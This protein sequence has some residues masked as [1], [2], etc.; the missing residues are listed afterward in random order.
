MTIGE[1]RIKLES[2]YNKHY[3]NVKT[4]YYVSTEKAIKYIQEQIECEYIIAEQIVHEWMTKNNN[5]EYKN[6]NKNYIEVKC[7]YCNSLNTTKISELS[8]VGRF[9]L[10][11]IFSLSK[12]SKQWHCNNCGSDF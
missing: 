3:E 8:K 9:A 5:I 4:F 1:A 12:N 11:G 10:W 2:N 6:P 7:P